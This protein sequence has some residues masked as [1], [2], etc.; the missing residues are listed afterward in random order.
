MVHRR[1]S[2]DPPYTW[3]QVLPCIWR[4]CFHVHGTGAPCKWRRCFHVNGTGAPCKWRRCFHGNGAGA[5]IY[6][7]Q[8]LPWKWRRCSMEMGGILQ[9][10]DY[11]R[12]FPDHYFSE[13]LQSDSLLPGKFIWLGGVFVFAFPQI[14]C[15][16]LWEWA[17]TN[18]LWQFVGMGNHKGCP[19]NGN[20]SI[21]TITLVRLA[22]TAG[23]NPT[24]IKYSPE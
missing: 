16:N 1:V 19:Y 10:D 7:A 21:W 11:L 14:T 13:F 24:V 17:T 18:Y 3:A 22:L 4:R 2:G 5:S 23:L 9:S 8:V 6:M 12:K 20:A 15:G